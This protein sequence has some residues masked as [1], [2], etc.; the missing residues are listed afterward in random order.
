MVHLKTLTITMTLLQD[1][2][3]R[4]RLFISICSSLTKM[5]LMTPNFQFDELAALRSHYQVGKLDCF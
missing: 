4:Q 1:P 3:R 5:K 2:T